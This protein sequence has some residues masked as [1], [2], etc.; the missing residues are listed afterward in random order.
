MTGPHHPVYPIKAHVAGGKGGEGRGS[1]GART[2]ALGGPG[3]D[4]APSPP[5]WM[6][7]REEG[8]RST[9]HPRAHPPRFR[10]LHHGAA[11]FPPCSPVTGRSEPHPPEATCPTPSQG[12]CTSSVLQPSSAACGFRQAERAG[13]R[14]PAPR[15]FLS[16]CLP[17]SLPPL[18]PF[19]AAFSKH[20]AQ[21]H[22]L[23]RAAATPSP[24]FSLSHS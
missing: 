19:S 6:A 4:R 16:V 11:H 20:S 9:E 1:R 8:M 18:C 10:L 22:P 23:S 2:R 3:Q 15:A 21:E 7:T 13:P 12:L 14:L 17:L 24:P 5:P